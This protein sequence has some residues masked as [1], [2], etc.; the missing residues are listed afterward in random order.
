M[1]VVAEVEPDAP[2]SAGV[3]QVPGLDGREQRVLGDLWRVWESKRPKN[4]L[5][6]VYHDGHR[7]FQ[8]LGISV[9]PQMGR[10][11]ASLGW[12]AKAVSA[13]ARKH[14]WEGFSLDG[15]SDPFDV[16]D[17]LQQN[18]FGLELAQGVASAYKHSCSFVTVTTGD[19]GAGEPRVVVQARDALW[20][21]ALW[22]RRNR[23]I[24][25]A[26]AITDVDKSNRP[27]SAVLFL[28]HEV[29]QLEKGR[30]VWSSRPL[31]NP[32]GRVLVEPLTY[33]P[34][35]NRPFGRSRITR[36]VRYLT[37]AA[38][39]TL[40][41]TETNAEFYASPQR[42]ALGVDEEAFADMD[43]W[44]AITGRLNVLTP[45]INGDIPQMGQFQ[46]ATMGP[47]LEMYRQLAQNFCS[48]TNLPQSAVGLF[49][50][51]PASAEA[52]Q[53]AEYA[54]SDEG[55]YQ[56]RVFDPR[57]VRV[58]QDVVM[59][60]DGLPEPPPESWGVQTRW[61]PCRYVSPQASSDYITKVVQALPRVADTDVALR[62][63]GF[64]QPEIDEMNAQRTRAAAPGVLQQLLARGDAGGAATGGVV[65]GADQG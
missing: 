47:H 30:G 56:W 58:V 63:A 62:K 29:Y 26:L 3:P 41:R 44:R 6:D 20:S 54:L 57:L 31:G 16:G 53:A 18:L 43:R 23:R 14:V 50:D 27:S 65:P 60:R 38:V 28:P 19:V 42:Y 37:D 46:Q 21:S 36:E 40:M 12:P 49:A 25:A 5:L 13:L 24:G 17:V 52:M 33:D 15:Q 64:T 55:E 11:R 51:N 7:A 2:L 8:D 35:L 59:L 4:S 39:R 48:A 61:T 9:P 22:D 45:N 32:T 34:Q 1:S 10:V